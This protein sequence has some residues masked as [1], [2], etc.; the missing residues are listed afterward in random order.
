MTDKNYEKGK[1]RQIYLPPDDDGLLT[2][3]AEQ[4]HDG[5]ASA[6][7][8]AALHVYASREALIQK[9]MLDLAEAIQPDERYDPADDDR[10]AAPHLV[11]ASLLGE[12]DAR[13]IRNALSALRARWAT[14]EEWDG[15]EIL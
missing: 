10:G 13:A 6:T 7:I 1:R 11:L 12:S 14:G 2:R 3:L 5:N 9:A 15:R 4:Y 8:I